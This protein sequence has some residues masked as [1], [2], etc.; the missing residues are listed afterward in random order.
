MPIPMGCLLKIFLRFHFYKYNPDIC[1]P[2]FYK[3][4]EGTGPEA[5]ENVPA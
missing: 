1:I 4:F 5:A 2:I 3:Y